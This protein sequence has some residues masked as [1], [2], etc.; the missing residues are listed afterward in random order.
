MSKKIDRV[1]IPSGQ[2]NRRSHLR[3]AKNFLGILGR[4]TRRLGIR[5]ENLVQRATTKHP[6]PG[7]LDSAKPSL[8]NQ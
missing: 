5:R 6:E 4:A 7:H 2:N 1:N 8:A 3:P